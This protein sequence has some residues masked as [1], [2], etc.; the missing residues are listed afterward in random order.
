MYRN[1]TP[2]RFG[3][4]LKLFS[5]FFVVGMVALVF[6]YIFSTKYI[7]GE[8]ENQVV[9]EAKLYNTVFKSDF[10]NY[11]NS[12][13]NE[14]TAFAGNPAMKK[15]VIDMVDS[16]SK[17][18]PDAQKI[19][20]KK[21]GKNV[22][23]QTQDTAAVSAATSVPDSDAASSALA[24][25]DA[26]YSTYEPIFADLEKSLYLY[27]VLIIDPHGTVLYS[28]EKYGDFAINIATDEK[29]KASE[30]S[31]IFKEASALKGGE[32]AL[33]DVEP[34]APAG[35]ADNGAYSSLMATPIIDNGNL[36]GV[37]V[38]R[39]SFTPHPA[40]FNY[41]E[42]LRSGENIYII[43]KDN[44][45]SRSING[46]PFKQEL[47]GIGRDSFVVEVSPGEKRGVAIEKTEFLGNNWQ[48]ITELN[49]DARI[50]DISDLEEGLLDKYAE[51]AAAS[52]LFFLLLSLLFS[53]GGKPPEKR[54]E[55]IG[56]YSR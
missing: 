6:G 31:L 38:F 55:R 51:I 41:K 53:R 15:L 8:A 50:Q 2:S 35:A 26:L 30:L 17:I 20:V 5:C 33:H 18:G 54:V 29:W 49:F 43:G 7:E 3:R 52:A 12:L 44:K 39:L 48:I 32:V 23:P 22:T 34:Y 24:F 27:D 11:L 36:L 14:I 46:M 13:R 37:L 25:Y 42:I 56:R 4:A 40:A 19:L 28:R 9:Q 16:Y 1:D 10:L 45:V 21:Y 47:L